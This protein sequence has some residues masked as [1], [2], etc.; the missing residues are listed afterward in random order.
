MTDLASARSASA[1]IP[2]GSAISIGGPTPSASGRSGADKTIAHLQALLRFDTRNPPGNERPAI[3][4]VASVL[5]ERGLEPEIF[6]AAPGRANLVCRIRGDGTGGGALLLTSHIDVVA[7]ER[8]RWTHDPFGAEIDEG[9]LW[10]RGTV[11]MKGLTAFELTTFLSIHAREQTRK[12]AGGGPT[13]GRDVILLVLCD[14]EAGMTYGSSYM[15]ENHPEKI[16]AEYAL[17]E[18]GAFSLT[19][20]STRVYPIQTAEKGHAWLELIAKGEPGHGSVPHGENAVQRLADAIGR[21]GRRPIALSVHPAAK[22]FIDVAADAMGG[23]AKLLLKG[24]LHPAT[25]RASLVALKRLQPE[26]ADFFHALLY[27]TAT[28]TMLSAGQKENVIPSTA[29]AVIDGRFV[30]GITSE[31][32]VR[33][34]KDRVGR[35]IE[36]NVIGSG[37]PSEAP[38]DTPLFRHLCRA[39]E[40]NDP[41][42]RAC[43]WLTVGYTDG[44]NLSKLGIKCYGFYPLKLPDD[45]KFA[46][47]VHGH[48]ERVPVDGYRWGFAVFEEAVHRFVYGE[49]DE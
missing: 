36:V 23:P 48:D 20:G 38:P 46:K 6:E 7:V 37:E 44:A 9:Y 3:D 8:E 41:G 19:M 13:L 2:S 43:P 26:R 29:R 16:R 22:G 17:N 25:S 34:I 42:A 30:P 49:I 32:Y 5:R 35:G 14:E 31:D 21:I 39:I 10:G 4:Y 33:L 18:F 24:L 11:D 1:Q 28:P 15:V 47:L 12:Q 27:H 40:R 45:L